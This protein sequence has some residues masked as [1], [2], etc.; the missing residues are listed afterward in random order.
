MGPSCSDEWD[1]KPLRPTKTADKLVKIRVKN[2]AAIRFQMAPHSAKKDDGRH[3]PRCVR[4]GSH[5]PHNHKAVTE[6]DDTRAR[7]REVVDNT[8]ECE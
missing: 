7:E 6:N 4:R 3:E 1:H 5:V 2:R 8:R